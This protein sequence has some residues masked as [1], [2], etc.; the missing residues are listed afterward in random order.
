MSCHLTISAIT[1][2]P[3]ET[4]YVNGTRNRFPF[5]ALLWAFRSGGGIINCINIM[6]MFYA[7]SSMV[8]PQNNWP[9]HGNSVTGWSHVKHCDNITVACLHSNPGPSSEQRPHSSLMTS[10]NLEPVTSL[11]GHGSAFGKC[12][13]VEAI[14]EGSQYHRYF[15]CKQLTVPQ[16]QP[17][18]SPRCQQWGNSQNGM[19]LMAIHWLDHAGIF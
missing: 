10:P 17:L 13:S 5:L 14:P 4:V 9:L 12:I 16:S 3:S 11:L 6:P 19:R 8:P 2:L 7:C 15:N 1:L 18:A